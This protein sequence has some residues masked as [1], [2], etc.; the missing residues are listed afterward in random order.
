MKTAVEFLEEQML[1][2]SPSAYRLMKENG[3]WQQAKEMEKDQM[4][5]FHIQV[6]KNGLEYE[7][8][9]EWNDEFLPLIL[10]RAEET[11]NETFK[12]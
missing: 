7:N 4:F 11:Y 12:S 10:E 9:Q 8:E 3:D 2:T 6:M 5:D 1:L